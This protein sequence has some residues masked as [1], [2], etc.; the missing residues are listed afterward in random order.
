[1]TPD[2]E[3]FGTALAA[4]AASC[5]A[6]AASFGV[7]I[8][9]VEIVLGLV[10]PGEEVVRTDYESRVEVGVSDPSQ[11]E[12]PPA[13]SNL[14]YGTCHE[15]GHLC[16][17]ASVATTGARL[18]PVVWDEAIAHFLALDVFLPAVARDHG[19]TLWPLPYPDYDTREV[20]AARIED[21]G[22]SHLAYGPLLERQTVELRSLAEAGGGPGRLLEAVA[23]VAATRA[24]P[25]DW[26]WKLRGRLLR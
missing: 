11:F 22:D 4:V 10:E 3:P 24:R 17:A 19:P 21:D 14:I 6:E 9:P 23:A 20:E 26:Q 13:G 5:R 15:V 18:P 7:E 8:A 16:I 12:P 1:V 25:E 2:L